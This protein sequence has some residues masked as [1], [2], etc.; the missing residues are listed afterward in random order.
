MSWE[1]SKRKG[2][3]IN[4]G[5]SY[6]PQVEHEDEWR[7]DHQY[8]GPTNDCGGGSRVRI[9]RKINGAGPKA[10]GGARAWPYVAAEVSLPVDS[11]Y[12]AVK[13]A[14]KLRDTIARFVRDNRLE[15]K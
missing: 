6:E 13:L 3:T 14:E 4:L 15:R 1:R 10:F 5:P 8:A 11:E 7:L 2:D 12:L 9:S